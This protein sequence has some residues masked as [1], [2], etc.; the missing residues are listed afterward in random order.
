MQHEGKSV[1][2][3][4]QMQ[5]DGAEDE[6]PH[7]IKPPPDDDDGYAAHLDRLRRLRKDED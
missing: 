5:Q 7:C 4:P 3:V 2:S 6:M 1:L